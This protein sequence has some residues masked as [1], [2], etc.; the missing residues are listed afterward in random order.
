MLLN[1]KV[2]CIF[3]CHPDFAVDL[4]YLCICVFFYFPL[5]LACVVPHPF[6]M[7]AKYPC[8]LCH[9][10]PCMINQRSICCDLCHNWV[11][12]KCTGLCLNN[13]IYLDKSDFPYF[14]VNRHSDIFPFQSLSN[15]NFNDFFTCNGENSFL[16]SL[17]K[18]PEYFSDSQNSYITTQKFHEK[19]CINN[20]FFLCYM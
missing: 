10:K 16:S 5:F 9:N 20:D 13:F 18:L 6:E 2:I 11:H 17:Q 15:E 3:F 4:L 1:C 7:P 12:Q 14:C 8:V 19:Y